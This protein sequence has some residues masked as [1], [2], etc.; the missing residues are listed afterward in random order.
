MLGWFWAHF[1]PLRRPV[2][3]KLGSGFPCA[4]GSYLYL[5]KSTDPDTGSGSFVS[6]SLWHLS[7][8]APLSIA[9][10]LSRISI[11]ILLLAQALNSIL[12]PPDQPGYWDFSDPSGCLADNGATFLAI[13][14]RAYCGLPALIEK[15][16]TSVGFK[17]LYFSRPPNIGWS[18]APASPI[19]IRSSLQL[20]SRGL[21][22]F[23]P[24]SSQVSAPFCSS[25]STT[26]GLLQCGFLGGGGSAP[27]ENH[28]ARP[29]RFPFSL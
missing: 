6:F 3:G 10:G 28:S 23:R 9:S 7:F 25:P 16:P 11:R 24:V 4:G 17:G 5:A 20:P 22:S 18:S 15:L 26:L 14:G 29:L 8:S 1:S 2:L 27:R 19:S 21:P 12:R 13:S